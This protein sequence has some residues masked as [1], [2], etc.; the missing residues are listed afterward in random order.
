VLVGSGVDVDVL[1]GGSNTVGLV[2]TFSARVVIGTNVDGEDTHAQAD[3]KTIIAIIVRRKGGWSM[4][5]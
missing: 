4:I 2:A 5:V 1:A 3:D